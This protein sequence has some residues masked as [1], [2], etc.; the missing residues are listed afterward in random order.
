MKSIILTIVLAASG[1]ASTSA[2]DAVALVDPGR[3]DPVS[4]GTL[5]GDARLTV[6]V[7]FSRTCPCQRAH[8]AR[9]VA[10]A[11]RWAP[12]GVAVIAIA[13]EE[14]FGPE[15]AGRE[16]AARGYPYPIVVDPEARLA[17]AVGATFAT[18]AAI[19]DRHG[20]LLFSG[21]IDSDV[22]KL[23]DDATPYLED[24]LVALASGRAIGA[25]G[26][27]RGCVLRKS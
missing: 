24:A 27:P 25:T 10:L 1:C 2:L 16:R 7:F 3:A 19:V 20:R 9:L 11:E 22:V 5:T 21:A 6:L 18:H 14:G 8:D 23:T 26:R 15:D 4:L 13:S 12:R 17:R